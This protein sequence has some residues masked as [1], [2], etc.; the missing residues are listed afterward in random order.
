MRETEQKY[1]I[2][3]VVEYCKEQ[4]DAEVKD[5]DER[6]QKFGM[7]TSECLSLNPHHKRAGWEIGAANAGPENKLFAIIIYNP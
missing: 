2:E 7:W 1:D 4:L 3:E 5:I 6:T